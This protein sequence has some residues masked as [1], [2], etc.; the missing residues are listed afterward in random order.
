M[1]ISHAASLQ[2]PVI[3]FGNSGLNL[4]EWTANGSSNSYTR[5]VQGVADSNYSSK[6]ANFQYNDKASLSLTITTSAG[7]IDSASGNKLGVTDEYL[8]SGEKITLSIDASVAE[9]FYIKTL[10]IDQL[11][12]SGLNSGDNVLFSDK[13]SQTISYNGNNSDSNASFRY[14]G[15][16]SSPA[17]YP[18]SPTWR[19]TV[20]GNSLADGLGNL[21]QLSAENTESWEI[22]IEATDGQLYFNQ[23]HVAYEV[24]EVSAVPEPSST[25]LI[26]LGSL[27]FLLRRKR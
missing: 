27:G 23:V 2:A 7:T 3:R 17:A 22:S 12:L 14:T 24:A 26:A 11:V 13:D 1:N 21:E 10:Y 9:G 20:G 4:E 16:P 25:G 18:D 6:G 8:D 15:S 19:P 5:T